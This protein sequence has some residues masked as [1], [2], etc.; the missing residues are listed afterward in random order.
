M[1]VSKGSFG[2]FVIIYGDQRVRM[3]APHA[4]PRLRAWRRTSV[5]YSSLYSVFE[6]SVVS[7]AGHT[8]K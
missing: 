4:R 6:R 7:V 5:E 1:F 8:V 3:V 2:V